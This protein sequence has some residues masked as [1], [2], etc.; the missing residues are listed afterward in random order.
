MD[1]ADINDPRNGMIMFHPFEHAFDRSELCFL[2]RDDGRF[3]MEIMKPSLR[4]TKLHQYAKL[5]N[6]SLDLTSESSI[7][8]KTFEE[9]TIDPLN[10]GD[11]GFKPFSRC[12]NFQARQARLYAIKK[13]WKKMSWDFNDFWSE[14]ND[15][16]NVKSWLKTM[17]SQSNVFEPI[18]V[19]DIIDI[20]DV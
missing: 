13:G 8:D 3:Y 10:F 12:L 5:N 15:I 1:F 17:D 6:L 19:D 4:D 18:P 11:T 7:L 9:F 16:E 20:P 14:T 2:K